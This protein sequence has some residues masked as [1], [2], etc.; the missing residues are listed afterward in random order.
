[1]L[2]LRIIWGSKGRWK[3]LSAWTTRPAVREL[4]PV[5]SLWAPLSLTVGHILSPDLPPSAALAC[6]TSKAGAAQGLSLKLG[7]PCVAWK[8]GAETCCRM[9]LSWLYQEAR[10]QEG[11]M[12]AAPSGWN[13][14]GPTASN[15]EFSDPRCLEQS[16]MPLGNRAHF[17]M[18]VSGWF[19]RRIALFSYCF[20]NAWKWLE[21]WVTTW[22]L[23]LQLKSR[24]GC[25]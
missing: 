24:K 21:I 3:S 14:L 2:E 22:V 7:S 19:Q 18:P 15:A 23:L 5:L 20:A 1:M 13:G 9:T 6:M 4:S 25:F 11:E 16:A 17:S 10:V 8:A 12:G